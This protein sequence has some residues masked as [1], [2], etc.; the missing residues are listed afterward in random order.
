M[1]LAYNNLAMRDG[2]GA[3]LQRIAEVFGICGLYNYKFSNVD[4]I[5][6]DSNPGDGMND[7]DT[8]DKFLSNLNDTLVRPLGSCGH[9]FHYDIESICNFLILDKLSSSTPFILYIVCI[10][11][12]S[13]KRK[14]WGFSTIL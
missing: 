6:I 11:R 5:K 3:Q 12:E 2:A 14:T 13:N 9:A 4:I 10:L 1:C 7:V 8:K